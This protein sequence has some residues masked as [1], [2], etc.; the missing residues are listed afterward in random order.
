MPFLCFDGS[1]V[2]P[3]HDPRHGYL[4]FG[5]QW[6][7]DMMHACCNNFGACCLACSP[8]ALCFACHLRGKA[9]QGDWTKYRCCQG[10]ICPVCTKCFDDC[11]R[12]C[13][14]CCLCLEVSLCHSLAISATRM[15]VQDER[16]ITTDP[17][18]NRIIRFNNCVQLLACVCSILSIFIR[19][20]R[21]FVHLLRLF[22]DI[23]YCSTQ[24]CMQSQTHLELA[25]HPTVQDYGPPLAQQPMPTDKAPLM[26]QYNQ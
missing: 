26:A 9:L 8:G 11:G 24:A 13:P 20:L 3:E 7:T 16:Q 10:Y 25:L 14:K 15:Y 4:A 2:E 23:V 12:D 19:E 6:E 21:Q 17:C 18:D 5:R 22:A 1:P